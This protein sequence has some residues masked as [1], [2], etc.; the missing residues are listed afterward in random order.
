M[1]QLLVVLSDGCPILGAAVR[2]EVV[3]PR[4]LAGDPPDAGES[5]P[6]SC[7]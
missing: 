2:R 7:L 1:G 6:F 4:G 3:I 5:P